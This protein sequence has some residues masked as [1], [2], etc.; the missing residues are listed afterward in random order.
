LKTA[1]VV[2]EGD[3]SDSFIDKVRNGGYNLNEGVI[4]KGGSGHKLWMR[5]IKTLAYLQ[6]LKNVLGDKWED[7]G[8]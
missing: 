1:Q 4:C 8:E 7:F 3:L 2:Y 5:K 6:R